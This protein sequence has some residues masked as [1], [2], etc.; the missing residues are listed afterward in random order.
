[1]RLETHSKAHAKEALFLEQFLERVGSL[2][3]HVL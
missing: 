3:P 2:F 1:M